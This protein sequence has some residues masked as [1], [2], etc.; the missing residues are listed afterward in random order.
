MVH[1]SLLLVSYL[2]GAVTGIFSLAL[3]SIGRENR[4][5]K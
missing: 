2:V 4:R 1:W 5:D 3:V